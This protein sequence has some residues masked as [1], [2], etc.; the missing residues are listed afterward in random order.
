MTPPMEY[1]AVIQAQNGSSLEEI[2]GAQRVEFL[3]APIAVAIRGIIVEVTKQ[4][5]Q[6]ER[7]ACAKI[8]E[9]YS[10]PFN[11]GLGQD[12]AMYIRSRGTPSR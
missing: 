8:A 2:L 7:E 11:K 10:I 9:A 12:I 3:L 4:A 6:A 5:V 1:E